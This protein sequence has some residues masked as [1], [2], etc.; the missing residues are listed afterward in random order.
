MLYDVCHVSPNIRRRFF[1]IQLFR[2]KNWPPYFQ[3]LENKYKMVIR[4]SNY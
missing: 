2:G 4:N 1:L 3:V